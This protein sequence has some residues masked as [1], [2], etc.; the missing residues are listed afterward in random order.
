VLTPETAM[1]VEPN[2]DSFAEGILRLLGD[3][4]LA[5]CLGENAH[6]LAQEKFNYQNYMLKVNKIYKT[7]ETGAALKLPSVPQE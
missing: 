5:Q 6:H 4:Q 7:L 2:R 3:P 1:L